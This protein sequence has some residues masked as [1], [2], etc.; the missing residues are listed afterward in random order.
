ML[1]VVLEKTFLSGY[2]HEQQ[3][4]LRNRSRR[5]G[6]ASPHI[7]GQITHPPCCT[8]SVIQNFRQARRKSKNIKNLNQKIFRLKTKL[9]EIW[10]SVG[11]LKNSRIKQSPSQM[12][13]CMLDT[14][15]G[16]CVCCGLR[17]RPLFDCFMGF[18][19]ESWMHLKL[20]SNLQS[21]LPLPS[22]CVLLPLTAFLKNIYFRAGEIIRD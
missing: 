7:S 2:R 9:H 20:S 19:A 16:R 13:S 11:Q 21:F 15:L 18:E 3:P 22:K 1:V 10:K 17:T 5:A 4:L 6:Q 14:A 8:S 12:A